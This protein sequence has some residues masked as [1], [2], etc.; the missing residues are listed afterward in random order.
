LLEY[1]AQIQA[2]VHQGLPIA[3][4]ARQVGVSR[5]T[6]Y[7]YRRMTSPPSPKQPGR[8]A[9]RLS[10]AQE[11]YVLARWNAGCRNA[12]Q[13][14][15]ELV[16]Q[17]YQGSARTIGRVVGYLRRHHGQARKFRSAPP[18]APGQEIRTT[19]DQRP[20]T[21]YRA[22]L[23]VISRPEQRSE[24]Q[25]TY[26]TRLCAADPSMATTY[27]QAQE[28]MGMVRERRGTQLDRWL[29]TVAHEGV[30]EL[31]SFAKG[32]QDDHAAVLAGLT[33]RWSQGQTEGQIHRLKLLKRQSYGRAGFALLRQRVL[34]KPE[35]RPAFRTGRSTHPMQEEAHS[36]Q[37]GPARETDRSTPLRVT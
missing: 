36:G 30:A 17:G 25:Q 22:A 14:W 34:L 27:R 9:R 4:I 13:I 10:A 12:W 20:Y 32:L 21:A 23:L 31:Q 37:W 7:R 11:E 24:W 5:E 28:F 6:V 19:R 33:L 15:Q 18:M 29:A 1:Y 8:T 3:A 16:G 26:L 35:G 2:L